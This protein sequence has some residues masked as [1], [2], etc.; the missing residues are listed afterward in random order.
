[1]VCAVLCL[2]GAACLVLTRSSFVCV[3]VSSVEIVT[4]PDSAYQT[5]YKEY[6]RV[7]QKS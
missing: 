7:L 6:T 5:V 4:L 3:C 1:M 2:P